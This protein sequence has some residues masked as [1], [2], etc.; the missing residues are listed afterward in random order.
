[1]YVGLLEEV[2]TTEQPYLTSY[3]CFTVLYCLS[4]CHFVWCFSF[5][6]SPSVKVYSPS[7]WINL[8]TPFPRKS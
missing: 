7:W 6:Y 2:A 1:M 4:A 8:H 3:F 5:I